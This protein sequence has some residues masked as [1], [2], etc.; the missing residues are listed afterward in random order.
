MNREDGF[1]DFQKAGETMEQDYQH[2]QQQLRQILTDFRAHIDEKRKGLFVV[3]CST[4][5]V[6]GKS[7]G[8]SGSLNIAAMIYEE[9]AAFHKETGVDLAFQCCEHLNRALVVD[10]N[11]QERYSFEEV[12]VIP[13]RDAGGAMAAVA[14]RKMENPVVVE[15]IQADYGL[16]IG[17]T[18]IGMHLKPVVVPVRASLRNV[19]NAHITLA[20]TRPKLIGGERAVY[21]LE[22]GTE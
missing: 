17:D 16:D 5:E 11:V 20:K 21:R 1:L 9:L 19:G 3:G 2:W 22:K 4:S 12:T 7:I 10:R 18:L 14:Y 15:K 13:V 8:T 6:A